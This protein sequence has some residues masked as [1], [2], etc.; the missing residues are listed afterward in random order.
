MTKPVTT[1]IR[2]AVRELVKAELAFEAIAH[3]G[4]VS[5]SEKQAAWQKLHVKRK[6]CSEAIDRVHTALRQA[7][8]P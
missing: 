2:K 8:L 7:G 3:E 6:R 5:G 4:N 1:S